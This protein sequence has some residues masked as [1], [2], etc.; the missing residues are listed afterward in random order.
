VNRE[1]L[2]EHV[3]KFIDETLAFARECVEHDSPFAHGLIWDNKGK[4]TVYAFD[5]SFM[6]NWETKNQVAAILLKNLYEPDK[7]SFTFISDSIAL[8]PP[9]GT[10]PEDIPNNYA[11]APDDWKH[12]AII[13]AYNAKNYKGFMFIQPYKRGPKGITFEE[14]LF[15]AGGRFAFDLTGVTT[16][17]RAISLALSKGREGRNTLH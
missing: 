1:D 9:E 16:S 12:E 11:N 17:A 7:E 13:G 2:P 4:M 5:S 10:K 3:Q 15:R 8:H 6:G 14:V